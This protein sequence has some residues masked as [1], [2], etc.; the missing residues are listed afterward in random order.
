MANA[1]KLWQKGQ[2]LGPDGHKVN[3]DFALYCVMI[4]KLPN[5]SE[6]QLHHHEMR[7]IVPTQLSWL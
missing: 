3:A 5:L 2:T 7:L 1:K 4:Y 6:P